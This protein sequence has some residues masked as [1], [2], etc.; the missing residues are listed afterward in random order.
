MPTHVV[1]YPWWVIF[2]HVVFIFI[3]RLRLA[4]FMFLIGEQMHKSLWISAVLLTILDGCVI[5]YLFMSW[6]DYHGMLF[7][8][9][10]GVVSALGGIFLFGWYCGMCVD[11]KKHP[12]LKTKQKE[13][14]SP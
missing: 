5:T 7:L 11:V 14:E 12:L 13:G 4:V 2:G 6:L 9:V 8:A 10:L 3:Q 1:S